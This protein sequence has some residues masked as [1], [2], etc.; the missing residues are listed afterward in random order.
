[1]NTEE[2]DSKLDEARKA[3]NWIIAHE[4]SNVVASDARE[5]AKPLMRVINGRK[6]ALHWRERNRRND[7]SIS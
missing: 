3:L 2:I 4:E 6:P 5:A 7:V 1:M